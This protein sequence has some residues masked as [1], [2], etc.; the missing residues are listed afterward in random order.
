MVSSMQ[1]TSSLV[2]HGRSILDQPPNQ[3]INHM[4]CTHTENR[5]GPTYSE[6]TQ[7]HAT[8]TATTLR[9]GRTGGESSAVLMRRLEAR[10]ESI[11]GS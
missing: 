11:R 3:P 9:R 5:R 7:L 1:C 2:L 6:S 8:V 4:N 10:L